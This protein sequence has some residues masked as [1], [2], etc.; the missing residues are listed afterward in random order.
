ME[1]EGRRDGGKAMS[2]GFSTESTKQPACRR[3]IGCVG[4]RFIGSRIVSSDRRMDKLAWSDRGMDR[5]VEIGR[6]HV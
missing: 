5:L 4:V 6:A 2:C 1:R 3:E